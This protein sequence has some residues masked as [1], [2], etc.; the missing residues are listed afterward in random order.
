MSVTLNTS[1]KVFG[2]TR[3][4]NVNKTIRVNI[5]ILVSLYFN[6]VGKYWENNSQVQKTKKGTEQ[7]ILNANKNHL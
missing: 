5:N 1:S 7:N 4:T 2:V 6:K 3:Q